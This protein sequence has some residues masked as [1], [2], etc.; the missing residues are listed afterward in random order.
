MNTAATLTAELDA[1]SENVAALSKLWNA[2]FGSVNPPQPFQF[3]LWLSLHPFE[4]VVVGLREAGKTFA[5]LQGQMSQEH[6]IRHSSKIM[7][8]R[9]SASI[10]I[11]TQKED[12]QCQPK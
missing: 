7:N 1:Q 11:P 10:A 4:R 3:H 12:K 8:A 5:K 9:K 6:L 2:S